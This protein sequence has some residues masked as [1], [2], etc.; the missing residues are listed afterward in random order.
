MGDT[1][2]TVANGISLPDIYE[3]KE[4]SQYGWSEVSKQEFSQ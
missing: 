4:R 1:E 3:K 2:Y